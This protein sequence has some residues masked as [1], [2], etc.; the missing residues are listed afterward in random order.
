[1]IEF[2]L[3]WGYDPPSKLLGYFD[4]EY[5]LVV[6]YHNTL[7]FSPRSDHVVEFEGHKIR[8]QPRDGNLEDELFVIPAYGWMVVKGD[9]PYDVKEDFVGTIVLCQAPM[10]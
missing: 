7:T 3:E 6:E 5:C 2:F 9:N 8:V 10:S 1:M 4:S